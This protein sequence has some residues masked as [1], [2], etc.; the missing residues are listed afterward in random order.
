MPFVDQV[1]L[2]LKAGDGGPGAVSFRRQAFEPR[3]G[4]DG[5]D[6]GRGGHVIFRV[7]PNLDSLSHFLFIRELK[8]QNGQA[9][10][11]NQKTG[12]SGKDLI[13]QV[14]PGTIVRD[15]ISGEVLLECIDV[16]DYLFLRGGR[17][18]KG[19]V[20]FKSSVNQAP[21]IAQPGEPGA[22]LE[23]IIELKILADVGLVG[24]PNA[25]K[26]SFLRRI[27]AAKPKVGDYPFTTLHP[28]LGVVKMGPG[29]SFTIADL[30]GIIDKAHQGF[31]L[32]LTFLKHA[33]RTRFLCHIIDASQDII[34]SH[35]IIHSELKS[36]DRRHPE[37]GLNQKVKVIVLNKI[38]LVTPEQL[39]DQI[40]RLKAQTP[41]P[42]LTM[43][44]VTGQGVQ[45]V[46]QFLWELYSSSVGSSGRVYG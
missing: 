24:L 5:G 25:G 15:A 11:G 30:P 1:K 45:S 21:R 36:Y 34:Q 3:G 41:L 32:G 29:E 18:G 12:R 40:L 7:N 35:K 6:G 26:S 28:V 37:A 17:G 16:K 4:P 46:I 31:G 8:A 20:H 10:Q 13:I 38:D 39:E 27:S 9:G 19:N 22:E 14:P 23:V 33:E 44:V 42:I 2:R 43:S